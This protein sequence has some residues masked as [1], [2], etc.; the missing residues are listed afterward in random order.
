MMPEGVWRLCST[1]TVFYMS[2]WSGWRLWCLRGPLPPLFNGSQGG[3]ALFLLPKPHFS[4]SKTK[5]S[6]GNLCW[7]IFPTVLSLELSVL[8]NDPNKMPDRRLQFFSGFFII[9]SNASPHPHWTLSPLGRNSLWSSN[10]MHSRPG[11]HPQS[12]VI[13]FPSISFGDPPN[14]LFH[15][16][17][18]PWTYDLTWSKE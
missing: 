1:A 18:W 13:G 12:H 11:G 16:G 10:Y 15:T 5:I 14:D 9:F 3:T 6:L 2:V 17:L 7:N 8:I 4:H